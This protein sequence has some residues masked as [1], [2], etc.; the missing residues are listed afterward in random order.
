MEL[1]TALLAGAVPL[2][3]A[4]A[5]Y[6]YHPAAT[7][8]WAAL[9]GS[10]WIVVD[11]ESIRARSPVRALCRRILDVHD[12][13][14]TATWK[15]PGRPLELATAV[16]EHADDIGPA[17]R[18]WRLAGWEGASTD[19]GRLF[20]ALTSMRYLRADAH[21]AAWQAAGHTA[22]SVAALEPSSAERTAIEA[23]TDARHAAALRSVPPE[24]LAELIT[25]VAGLAREG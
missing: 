11:D 14:T 20:L 17:F 19:A 2:D 12:E 15:A 16:V 3:G 24:T 22:S 1:R 18:T 5:I 25:A 6:R 4:R 23:D 21:A 9:A 13:V 8:A 10:G 7:S